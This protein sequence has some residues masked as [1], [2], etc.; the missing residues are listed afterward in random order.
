[1]ESCASGNESGNQTLVGSKGFG[2]EF[3]RHLNGICVNGITIDCGRIHTQLRT[4]LFAELATGCQKCVVSNPW[5]EHQ[6]GMRDFPGKELRAAAD[7][8][9]LILRAGDDLH[10]YGNLPQA[11][12]PKG[13]PRR[14]GNREH[15][16][17]PWIAI[18][19]AGMCD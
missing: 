16:A 13:R 12:R 14:G 10:W 11:L 18:R 2:E 19:V 1:M 17:H 15:S 7:R 4:A 6:P 5:K 3:D 8:Y 9:V